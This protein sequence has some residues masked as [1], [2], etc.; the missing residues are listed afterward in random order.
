MSKD[1]LPEV[2]VMNPN[3][4]VTDRSNTVD[5]R[6]TITAQLVE[7]PKGWITRENAKHRVKS[8]FQNTEYSQTA[9]FRL[10]DKAFLEGDKNGK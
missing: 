7:M 3:F 8:M 10:V 2:K 6:S 1:K 4:G 9:I 5:M